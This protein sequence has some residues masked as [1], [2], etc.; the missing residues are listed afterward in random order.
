MGGRY[1]GMDRDQRAERT[2]LAYDAIVH[3]LGEPAPSA[4][5]AVEAGY[6]RGENDEFVLPTVID[7]VD[8]RVRDGDTIVHANFRADRARQ[9]TH[10]LVDGDRSRHSIAP[11]T[12]RS[13]VTCWS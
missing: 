7:G 1:Y 10:A 9:L 2:A 13:R 12:A 3:G 5:A 11:P 6:A 4:A 8:G